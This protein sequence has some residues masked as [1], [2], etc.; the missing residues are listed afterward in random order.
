MALMM[1]TMRMMMTVA[2]VK[3]LEAA[4]LKIRGH[5]RRDRERTRHETACTDGLRPLQADSG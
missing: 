3:E 4:S 2:T 5:Q 1:T